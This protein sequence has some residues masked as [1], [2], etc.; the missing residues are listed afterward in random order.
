MDSISKKFLI[1]D[2]L[3]KAMDRFLQELHPGLES[4][5]SHDT[6][7]RFCTSVIDKFAFLRKLGITDLPL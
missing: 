2:N 1:M 5:P 4:T 7:R 3:A 6:F